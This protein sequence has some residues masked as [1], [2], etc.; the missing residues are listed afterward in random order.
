M[1]GN[2]GFSQTFALVY[3]RPLCIST[4]GVSPQGEHHPHTIDYFGPNTSVVGVVG[5]RT[6]VDLRYTAGTKSTPTALQDLSD[7]W[8]IVE[9]SHGIGV[10]KA[11]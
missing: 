7:T 10:A 1:R 3:N 4:S 11:L 2:N 6:Q 9:N 8:L 5:G